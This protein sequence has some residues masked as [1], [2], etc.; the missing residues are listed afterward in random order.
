MEFVEREVAGGEA[1]SGA[2]SPDSL[3]QSP[4]SQGRHKDKERGSEPNLNFSFLGFR[5]CVVIRFDF[6]AEN[7]SNKILNL[8]CF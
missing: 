8:I 4:D 6:E 2:E 3:G 7:G 5:A 1:E